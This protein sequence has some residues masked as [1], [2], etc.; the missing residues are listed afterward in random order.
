MHK[1]AKRCLPTHMLSDLRALREVAAT[2]CYPAD[3]LTIGPVTMAQVK[4]LPFLPPDSIFVVLQG[5]HSDSVEDMAQRPMSPWT[6]WTTIGHPH[7]LTLL[8]H[9]NWLVRQEETR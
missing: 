1:C 7:V 4:T 9:I 2:N 3:I 8:H 6:I 5:C